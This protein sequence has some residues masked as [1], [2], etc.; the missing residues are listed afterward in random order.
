M[1]LCTTDTSLALD[2]ETHKYLNNSISGKGLSVFSFDSYLKLQLG[3]PNGV[4]EIIT[5]SITANQS[6]E[7]SEWFRDGGLYEDKPPKVLPYIRSANHFH[8]PLTDKGFTGLP[9]G[10][11]AI[12]WSQKPVGQQWIG[13]HYSWFDTREKFYGALVATDK[14]DRD[15]KLAETFRGVG[16]LMHL[17]QDMSVP[18]HVRNDF[19][20]LPA[21][22]EWLADKNN[23]TAAN[24]INVALATPKYPDAGLLRQPSVQG[25]TAPIP[26]ANL[27]DTNLFTGRTADGTTSLAYG[28]S[29]YAN[30]N[31]FSPDSIFASSYPFPRWSAMQEWDDTVNG[32]KRTYLRKV[33]DGELLNHAATGKWFYKYLPVAM[34]SAGYGLKLDE[35][36]YA[37]YAQL[38]LPRAVGYSAAML[39]YFFRGKIDIEL[40]TASSTLQHFMVKL[41]NS[42]TTN[43]EMTGGS[44]A[45]AIKY[46]LR[47]ESGGVV[48]PPSSTSP[49]YYKVVTLPGQYAIPRDQ[50]SEQIFDL[51]SD[52]LPFMATD[53][54]LQ[55]I[56]RGQLGN[57]AGA[58]AV[59][60]IPLIKTGT[61]IALSLPASGVYAKA[62]PNASGFTSIAVNATS[63]SDLNQPDGYFEL[64]VKYRTA[65]S[66]PFQGVPVDSFPADYNSF[67]VIRANAANG[68]AS[69]VKGVPTELVFNLSTP[70]PLWATDVFLDVLYRRTGTPDEKPLAIGQRDISEPTPV[71]LF[72]N[73]DKVCINNNWYDSGSAEAYAAVGTDSFGQPLDDIFSHRLDDVSFW[74]DASGKLGLPLNPD[75]KQFTAAS[76]N[77]NEAKRLG[78][79]LTDYGF[80]YAVDEQVV[81][82][83]L[84]DDWTL[85]YQNKLFGGT[86]FT[87]QLDR[88]FSGMYNIRGKKIWW[89]TSVVYDNNEDSDTNCGWQTIPQ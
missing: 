37:D 5:S 75:T 31:F 88:G 19:H 6:L 12:V 51:G 7:V 64:L 25:S 65:T 86:G 50:Q 68:V 46:R 22:E 74:A 61:D 83:D 76:V 27:F 49:Y 39:D 73:T 42:T 29:E 85:T 2:T 14:V 70:L 72:N 30:A 43:E 81:P 56:Y 52:P 47:I 8:D 48:A 4:K 89:G 71:D 80:G 82:L 3:L 26:I 59:G 69:L 24:I 78:Y 58:V 87:N 40:V 60:M 11:S 28:L 62:E 9:S 10:D 32:K 36:V 23:A 20:G 84:R 79:I 77:P 15:E 41:K 67:S 33:A 44:I 18:E 63:A 1:L 35:K 57:E 13:G 17:M 21:Y 45:L 34:K 16:Q 66:D 55:V 54:T 38:L 53:V